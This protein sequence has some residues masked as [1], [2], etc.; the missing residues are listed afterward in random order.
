MRPVPGKPKVVKHGFRPTSIKVWR[1][2]KDGATTQRVIDDLFAVSASL[3][4]PPDISYPIQVSR[5]VEEQ[6]AVDIVAVDS[7]ESVQDRF[8][9]A[10]VG[11]RR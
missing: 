4:G 3:E 9:P 1:K 5:L 8:P 11:F 2:F 10:S 7:V 6:P